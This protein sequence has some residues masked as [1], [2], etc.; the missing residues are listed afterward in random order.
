MREQM[1][2]IRLVTED[3]VVQIVREASTFESGW[4]ARKGMMR[5]RGDG[6]EKTRKLWEKASKQ[7]GSARLLDALKRYLREEKEPTC[8][9]PGLS[10]WLNGER[11]DHWMTAESLSGDSAPRMQSFPEPYR[12][13]LA[14]DLG[15]P[16]VLSYLDPCMFHEDNY[17]TPR[18][19]TAKAKLYEKRHE[20]RA[21]GIV[22][23]RQK[24]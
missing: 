7:V 2:Q 24:E 22:G 21:A 19:E 20:L 6:R 23:L 13:Q 5:K 15:E 1:R 16:F 4:E 12:A 3:N 18:T 9:Y 17:I 10:V 14:A 11:Y 8:G